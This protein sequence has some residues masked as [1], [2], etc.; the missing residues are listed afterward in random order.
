MTFL[1]PLPGAPE[2]FLSGRDPDFARLILRIGPCA[3]RVDA[4][5][6]PYEALVRAIAFQQIHGRA[7]EAILGR[8]L[9]LYPG[10]RFPD[11]ESVLATESGLMRAAGFSAGKIAAIR[12]IAEATVL[13]VVPARG[14]AA[15]FDDE[16]LI[17]RMVSIR[18]V[19]RWTVEMMLMHTLGRPDILPVDD[20]GVREGWRALKGLAKQPAPRELASAGEAF[21]PFRSAASWY[22]WRAADEA[23]LKT[24]R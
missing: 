6:E 15:S 12:A 2:A 17:Q 21:R 4:T 24:A 23:K 9:D 13:G 1:A 11:P 22:L 14:E 5:R 18:G 8:F 7:A 20:F 19:G 3:L 10:V 16:M